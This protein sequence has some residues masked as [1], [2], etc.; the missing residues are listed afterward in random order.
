MFSSFTT[1]L[2]ADAPA[3]NRR[4]AYRLEIGR[5]LFDVRSAGL[6]RRSQ[7]RCVHTSTP[8]HGCGACPLPFPFRVNLSSA[9]RR[10]RG[11][12]ALTLRSAS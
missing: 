4:R 11:G 8:P 12:A 2:H 1:L 7:V 6:K 3:L 5:D 10:T 9:V